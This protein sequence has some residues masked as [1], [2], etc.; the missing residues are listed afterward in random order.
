M[1]TQGGD[2]AIIKRR[3]QGVPRDGIRD[4]ATASGRGRLKEDLESSTWRWHHKFKATPS[5]RDC[6]A[7]CEVFTTLTSCSDEMG[8]LVARLVKVAMFHDRC[9]T[10]EEVVALKEPF[11]LENMHGY[12][13]TSK[14]EFDQA[15]DDLAVVSYPFI[16]EATANPYA[17]LE[18][19]LSKKP[20][21]LRLKPAPSN[22]KP[23]SL[24]APVS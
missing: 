16:A 23:S 15:S 8:L 6:K 17:S 4:P 22:S 19:L 7:S 2:I 10:F 9:E 5:R 24:K 1:H 11:Y 21:S 3:H 12:R 18:E 20:K 14:K 13:P